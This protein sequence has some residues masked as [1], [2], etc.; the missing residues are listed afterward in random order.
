MKKS[1]LDLQGVKIIEK[2]AQSKV[3]GGSC[4]CGSHTIPGTC[5]CYTSV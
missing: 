1:I 4:G 5:L 3:N 2:K